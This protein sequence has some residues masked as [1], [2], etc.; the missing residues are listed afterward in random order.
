MKK[1]LKVWEK[2]GEPTV[3]AGKY[4]SKLIS[5]NFKNPKT[6]KEEEYVLYTKKDWSTVLPIT[7]DGKV[8]SILQYKQG[9]NQIT[10]ELPGGTGEFDNEPPAD[11]MRR[12]LKEETGYEAGSVIDLGPGQYPMTRETLRQMHPFLALDCKKVAEQAVDETEEIEV[13]IISLQEWIKLCH[14]KVIEPGAIVT[15]FRALPYLKKHFSLDLN[16]LFS[17]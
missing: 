1:E 11:V 15:T 5:Q 3:L 9:C 13:E 10:R 6:G 14:T 8:V 4:G 17:V 2:V 16:S 12:E 7:S